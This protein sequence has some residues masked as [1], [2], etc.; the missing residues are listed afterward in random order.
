VWLWSAFE[1]DRTYTM[2][3]NYA[4]VFLY[5]A[6]VSFILF[7]TF[8][9]E[10]VGLT[11]TSLSD[12]EEQQVSRPGTFKLIRDHRKDFYEARAWCMVAMVVA[13][14]LIV[15]REE[16]A[17]PFIG[18]FRT[19]NP[20]GLGLRYLV[21]FGLTTFPLVGSHKARRK[22]WLARIQIIFCIGVQ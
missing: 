7:L 20:F 14:T 13:I 10:G 4:G 6:R 12:K 19:S 22:I 2:R 9:L 16:Y 17:I 5:L 18:S 15:A 8:L 21:T 3:R 1:L 11:F